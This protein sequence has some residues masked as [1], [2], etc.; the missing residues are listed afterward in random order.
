MKNVVILA[1]GLGLCASGCSGSTSTGGNGGS[2]NAGGSGEK[3]GSGGSGGNPASGGSAGNLGSG[4]TGG[5]VGV[6]G[7]DGSAGALGSGG[8]LGQ[9]GAA[10]ASGKGGSGG[11]A[12]SG[13]CDCVGAD[14]SWGRDGGFVAYTDSSTVSPCRTYLHRREPRAAGGQP[15]TC[16][17]ELFGCGVD[18]LGVGDLNAALAHADVVAALSRAPV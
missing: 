16:T 8:N 18:A 9:A 17:L 2:T 14:V 4:G 1:L 5:G 11:S 15:I 10:G 6:G 12:G 3:S 7:T 13:G